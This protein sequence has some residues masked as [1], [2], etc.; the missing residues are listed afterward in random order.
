MEMMLDAVTTI[1][2]TTR[3]RLKGLTGGKFHGQ[4]D[5]EWIVIRR[6]LWGRNDTPCGRPAPS[7][8]IG[9]S[10]RPQGIVGGCSYYLLV[11]LFSNIIF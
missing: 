6:S 2:T 5:A 11:M 3:M 10:G 8:P 1:A 4:G 9:L 7:R